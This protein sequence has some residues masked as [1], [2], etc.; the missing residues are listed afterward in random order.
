MRTTTLHF[1]GVATTPYVVDGFTHYQTAELTQ[2]L[3]DPEG[4]VEIISA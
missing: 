4:T 1:E 2:T 3:T